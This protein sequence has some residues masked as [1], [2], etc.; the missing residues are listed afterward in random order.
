MDI[1]QICKLWFILWWSCLKVILFYCKWTTPF[2]HKL[3]IKLF[4]KIICFDKVVIASSYH[5]AV[6]YLAF[7]LKIPQ[8]YINVIIIFNADSILASTMTQ[9]LHILHILSSIIFYK[10]SFEVGSM[11]NLHLNFKSGMRGS[12][13]AEK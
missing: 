13:E 1:S 7:F 3:F 11:N 5:W 10:K 2:L 6:I 12:R 8:F 4:S 9:T